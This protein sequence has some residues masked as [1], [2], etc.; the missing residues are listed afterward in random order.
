MV[1]MMTDRGSID[2]RFGIAPQCSLLSSTLARLGPERYGHSGG[3]ERV[4]A[5]VAVIALHTSVHMPIV[6]N[7][8][9]FPQATLHFM[10]RATVS[11]L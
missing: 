11:S 7:R 10:P 8:T 9:P 4:T 3:I 2:G 6:H 1:S 5:T